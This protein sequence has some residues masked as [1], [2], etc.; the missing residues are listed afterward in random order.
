FSVTKRLDA[1]SKLIFY[2]VFMLSTFLQKSIE[3]VIL[4]TFSLHFTSYYYNCFMFS[5]IRAFSTLF[6]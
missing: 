1:F 4:I 5:Y 6:S 3:Y 2:L